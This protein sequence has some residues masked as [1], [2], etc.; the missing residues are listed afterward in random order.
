MK[1]RG[2]SLKGLTD[3]VLLSRKVDFVIQRGSVWDTLKGITQDLIYKVIQT[4]L[5]KP[6]RHY[7]A[8]YFALRQQD[9]HRPPAL[10]QGARQPLPEKT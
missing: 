3:L 1:A 9:E 6:P 5:P 2:N 7:P 4:H 10:I 8:I